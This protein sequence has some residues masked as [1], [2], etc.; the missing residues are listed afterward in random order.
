MMQSPFLNYGRPDHNK[1]NGYAAR[2]IDSSEVSFS[3]QHYDFT[4]GPA[5]LIIGMNY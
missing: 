1:G 4:C 5:S 3:R 2:G